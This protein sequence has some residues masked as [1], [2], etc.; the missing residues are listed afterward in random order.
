MANQITP[1]TLFTHNF[2]IKHVIATLILD[3]DSQKN[4][5]AQTLVDTL[6]LPTTPHPA[7]YELGWVQKDGPQIMVSQR[8]I[9]TFSI[10]A[11]HDNVLCD[12]SSLDCADLILGLSYQQQRHVVYH[13]KNQQYHLQHNGCTYVLTSSPPQ[14]PQVVHLSSPTPKLSLH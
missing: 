10:G 5:V 8:C 11:F 4:I 14:M 1:P 2:Q 13:V 3:N 9:V 7:P 12:V 6:H